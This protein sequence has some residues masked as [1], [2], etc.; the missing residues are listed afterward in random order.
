MSG[1]KL[2]IIFLLAIAALVL[3]AVLFVVAIIGVAFVSDGCFYRYNYLEGTENETGI[4]G[5]DN[6]EN[7]LDN[8]TEHA[9][10]STKDRITKHI[11]LK[12]NGNYSASS[13]ELDDPDSVIDTSSYGQWRN[14]HLTVESGQKVSLKVNGEVS[15]CKGYLPANNIQID[16]D[17]NVNGEKIPIPRTDDASSA[18]VSLIFDATLNQWRNIAQL[19]KG[20]RVVVTLKKDQKTSASITNV[21]DTINQNNVTANCQEGLASYSPIC[22]RYSSWDT[23]LQYVDKCRFVA[24]CY[25]C[26]EREE[27]IG[28]EIAGVCSSGYQTVT[29]LCS[30]YENE[31]GVAPEPYDND[32]KYTYPYSTNL[33]DLQV[34]L[35]RDCTTEQAYVDGD[36]QNEKYFWYSAN[37]ATGLLYRLDGNV[38]PSNK[39]SLG[40][41]YQF[42]EIIRS[43]TLESGNVVLDMIHEEDNRSYLQ[44]RLYTYEDNAF[45][46]G[47]YVLGVKQTKCRRINGE[48][49][50]DDGYNERG[51]I[52]YAIAKSD[53]PPGDSDGSAVSINTN[54]EGEID[55]NQDGNV[56]L[57]IKNKDEDYKDSFGQYSVELITEIDTGN[58]LNDILTPFVTGFKNMIQGAS[59]RMFQNMTCFNTPDDQ[60]DCRSF[61]N[62]IRGMLILYV[63]SYGMCFLMGMVQITQTDLVIRVIKIGLVAGLMNESTFEFFRDYIFDM[64]TNF[65]DEI[66]GNMS[67]YSFFSDDN[68]I[69]NPLSFMSEV[70]TKILLSPTFSAQIMA[71]LSMGLNGIVYFV[72]VVIATGMLLIVLFRSITIYLMSFMA[73]SV[74]MGLAPLFL[75]FILFQK[76]KY[77]FDN[78]VKYC[79]RY[80]LEPV[81][82]LA[83]VIVITQLITIF[84]DNVLGFSVCWKCVLPIRIPFPSIEGVTPGLLGVDIFCIHWFAPWGFDPRVIELG[85]NL[86]YIAILLILVYCLWGYADFSSVL[87]MRITSSFGSPSATSMGTAVSSA[88]E[89]KALETTGL[90]ARSRYMMKKSIGDSMKSQS[91]RIDGKRA[92]KDAAN[93]TIH[94]VKSK[95]QGKQVT[96]YKKEKRLDMKKDKN[97][98]E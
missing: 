22:G 70:V 9:G 13:A 33:N 65:A 68:N 72:C 20:D 81:V 32:G 39:S 1:Q 86:Q 27:C 84:L 85:V 25:E 53:S 55:P 7:I 52:Q 10:L 73:L 79:F 97:K 64:I 69:S 12:A 66:I 74:L 82:L 48:S 15:L 92:V 14:T 28:E 43:S 71:L 47:G 67:G 58:F 57:K 96:D 36:Y 17:K 63:M 37:D 4:F 35:D 11:T 44:Y 29:D 77:L 45:N 95:W 78:W 88:I 93:Q 80:M 34:N 89:Q 42:A 98:E 2:I 75:T 76:T 83:G 49:F 60:S 24:E 46:T 87:V 23:N 8:I 91:K 50:D 56:W 54:G 5:V 19:D 59:T 40:S 38:D 26:N 90:D 3:C 18:P 6:P 21:Y 16:S 51:A 62:Y 30:C 94:A 61:F 31:Y 41:N